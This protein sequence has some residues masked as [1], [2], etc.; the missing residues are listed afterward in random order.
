MSQCQVVAGASSLIV[1]H[2]VLT[3]RVQYIRRC[4]CTKEGLNELSM[5][6]LVGSLRSLSDIDISSS[7]I[8]PRYL[9]KYFYYAYYTFKFEGYLYKSRRICILINC[10]VF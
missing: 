2:D 1:W 8:F 10:L 5:V 6:W 3:H 7:F 4:A 9:V